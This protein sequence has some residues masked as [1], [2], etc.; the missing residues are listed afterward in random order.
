[1]ARSQPF[2]KVMGILSRLIVSETIKFFLVI[3]SFSS[4]NKPG[5]ASY[6][7]PE[8]YREIIITL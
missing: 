5:G 8:E 7:Y 6:R 1:M 3:R 4:L 2:A